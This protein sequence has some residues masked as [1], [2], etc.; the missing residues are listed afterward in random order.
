MTR[1]LSLS[2]LLFSVTLIGC[3]RTEAPGPPKDV[4]VK[5]PNNAKP[6]A[7]AVTSD[8]MAGQLLDDEDAV[9]VR[10]NGKLVSVTGNVGKVAKNTVEFKKVSKEVLK[11]DLRTKKHVK[12]PAQA[13]IAC[14]FAGGQ[15]EK[16]AKLSAGQ[17][18][19]VTGH[20]PGVENVHLKDCVLDKVHDK[21]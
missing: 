9:Y 21:E 3:L 13:S 17:K 15:E 8:D 7:V 6:E 10:Y 16:L 14:D 19:T 5:G 18:I 4:V 11:L 1:W 2:V 12:A 20:F